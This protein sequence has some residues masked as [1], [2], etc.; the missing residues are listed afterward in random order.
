MPWKRFYR[1]FAFRVNIHDFSNWKVV[2]V[3]HGMIIFEMTDFPVGKRGTWER[4]TSPVNEPHCLPNTSTSVWLSCFLFTAMYVTTIRKHLRCWNFFNS[5]IPASMSKMV[6]YSWGSHGHF[7]ILRICFSDKG[8]WKFKKG[9][10]DECFQMYPMESLV[11]K[12]A[13]KGLNIQHGKG[14]SFPIMK[15]GIKI[16]TK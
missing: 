4:I 15:K 1:F 13:S 5:R 3:T 9:K 7:Q 8:C 6:W 2:A 11:L 12:L 14:T 10:E 16:W